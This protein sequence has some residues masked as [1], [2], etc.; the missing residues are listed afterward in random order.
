MDSSTPRSSLPTRSASDHAACY[1]NIA[2]S[3]GVV[4]PE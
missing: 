2:P 3:Y 1:A 4:D